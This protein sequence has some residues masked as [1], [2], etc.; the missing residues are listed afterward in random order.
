VKS[1]CQIYPY[2]DVYNSHP[3]FDA[4]QRLAINGLIIDEPDFEFKPEKAV[5][6]AEANDWINRLEIDLRNEE[7]LGLTRAGAFVKIFSSLKNID[8]NR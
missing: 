7:L 8:T 3:A 4:V 6:S 1:G 5:T 2:K